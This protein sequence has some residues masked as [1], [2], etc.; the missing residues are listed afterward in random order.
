MN[1][2]NGRRDAVTR[3]R[4]AALLSVL[5]L[6]AC[7]DITT[8][9]GRATAYFGDWSGPD[10]TLTVG[11]SRIVYRRSGGVLDS[12]YLQTTFRGL[13]GNDIVYGS[14][15]RSRLRVDVPPHRI[16]KVWKMT[17]EGR[18]LQRR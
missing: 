3:G 12:A 18:E 14:K 9:P 1:S 15:G 10:V 6:G 11:P 17:V 4:W 8:P 13:S 16:G 2:R 7:V 5:L